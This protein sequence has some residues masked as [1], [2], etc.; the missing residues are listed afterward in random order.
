MKKI[1]S[2]MFTLFAFFHLQGGN[3][4]WSSPPVVISGTNINA[5]NPVL[6]MDSHGNAVAAWAE[7][8]LIKASSHPFSGSWT[9]EV[10]VSATGASSPSLVMDANGNAT[11]VWIGASGVIFAS[12]KTLTGNWSTPT[13]LSN[14]GASTPVIGVDGSGDVVAAWARAGNI[15]TQTKLFGGNW[16]GRTT[17]TSTAAAN[18]AVAIGGSGTGTRAFVVWQGTSGGIPVVFA[19]T[20]LLSGSW[21]SQL[22]LSN[23]SN[24]AINPKIAVDSNA[25]AIAVWYEYNITGVSYTN[26]TVQS[27]GRLAATGAWDNAVALSVPGIR[28]PSA[29]CANVAFDG[30]G[31]AV[32]VWNTSF[33]DETFT[34]QSAVQPLNSQWSNPQDIIDSN[35]YAYSEAIAATNFGDTL[36]VYMYYNGANLLLQSVE[37]NINGYLNNVWSVPLTISA[38]TDN[39]YPKMVAT[40]NNNTMYSAVVW[41][42]FDGAHTSVVAVTGS[43]SLLLPPSNLSVVQSSS[44]FGVFT[45]YSNTLSWTA[46]TDPNAAGYLIFRNGLFIDQ[47]GAGVTQFV[48]YNRV[49]NGSVVYS[50]TTVDAGQSQSAAVSVSFP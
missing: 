44:N 39:A 11:L 19:S 42:H 6:A 26:V 25:N 21:A 33:D 40:V 16:Q 17:I 22:V 34:I 2:L 13:S 37:S 45:V 30:F 20:K 48:D 47:V 12:T 36:G 1:L 46:S 23:T 4:N 29:L 38:G 9:S 3:I 32:A 18:P 49:N 10:I 50:V 15:E 5:V 41:S 28:N 14:S 8:N 31:N 35:L 24:N 43:K 7:N 27:S